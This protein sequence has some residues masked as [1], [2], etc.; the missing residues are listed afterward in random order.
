VKVP[1]RGGRQITLLDLATHTSGLPREPSNYRYADPTNPFAD[2][3]VDDLYAFLSGHQLTRDI[4]TTFDYSNL[5]AGLLGHAL[6]RRAG[7]DFETLVRT[8]ITG[9]LGMHDTV[10]TLSP[11]QRTRL[12]PGHNPA[13]EQVPN[14]DSPT[15]AGAGSLYS[16]ANDLLTF[17]EA[18][19]EAHSPLDAAFA[20]IASTSRAVTAPAPVQVPM[21]WGRIIVQ[22]SDMLFANGRT[23]GYRSWMGYD[24]AT[25]A[26][27]VILTNT[28][29]LAEPDDLGR[30]WLNP[31]FPLRQ[32]FATVRARPELRLDPAILDRYVGQYEFAP[33]A[34][35]YIRRLGDR[36]FARLLDQ[37]P[38]EIFAEGE[39]RFFYKVV[40][41]Q[42]S[43]ETNE[44]GETAAAVL[45]QGGRQQRAVR[46]E[47]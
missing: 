22:D 31:A 17:L 5:G 40:D 44:T 20:L 18:A 42:I 14:W 4:G 28:D 2:Y 6:A 47:R 8:R 35:L 21:G 38:A 23:G 16:T 7:V 1:E 15:L 32:E 46:V 24:R 43:F 12:A 11:E 41:A 39:G 37:P 33:G 25:K 34:R 13:F 30:H 29:S 27:V 36:V 3:T 26:G 10:I 19:G 9:P 45:H